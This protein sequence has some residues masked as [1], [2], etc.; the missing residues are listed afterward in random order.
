MDKTNLFAK[1]EKDGK[2]YPRRIV[3]GT[4]VSAD[5][6][7]DR[8][9]FNMVVNKG[10][11]T[12]PEYINHINVR[13]DNKRRADLVAG[14]EKGTPILAILSVS[15]NT[16]D[17]KEYTNY[18]LDSFSL[19]TGLHLKFVTEDDKQKHLVVGNLVRVND[20]RFVSFDLA[21]NRGK[22]KEAEFINNITL[23]KDAPENFVNMIRNLQKGQALAAIVT[24]NK[25][26]KE[27]K[28]YTNYYLS[29][30][31]LFPRKKSE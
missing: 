18:W 19:G 26:T 27:D 28:T 16:K 15:K 12:E 17:N 24:E 21:V 30:L 8:V 10:K 7:N 9:N 22:D 3:Y 2:T 5:T 11:D 31:Q 20:E 6:A 13:T 4:F 29:E 1:S 23:S 25:V 14:L